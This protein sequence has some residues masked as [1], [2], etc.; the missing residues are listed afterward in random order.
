VLRSAIVE[1]GSKDN[2]SNLSATSPC[3]W[4][5]ISALTGLCWHQFPIRIVRTVGATR[6]GGLSRDGKV[7]DMANTRQC[8]PS[9][10]IGAN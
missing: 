6:S 2:H 1:K 9:E 7:S 3:S 5:G 4:F 10:A 8:L